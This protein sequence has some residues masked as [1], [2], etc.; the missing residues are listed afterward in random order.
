LVQKAATTQSSHIQWTYNSCRFIK[1]SVYT[2]S[3][4]TIALIY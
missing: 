3:E 4:E 2:A 1:P